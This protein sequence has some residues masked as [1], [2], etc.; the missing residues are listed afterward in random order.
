MKKIIAICILTLL[1]LV[2]L[3]IADE[4]NNQANITITS[5]NNLAKVTITADSNGTGGLP[6]G[7]PNQPQPGISGKPVAKINC[8]NEMIMIDEPFTFHGAY[9]AVFTPDNYTMDWDFGDGTTVNNTGNKTIL[10]LQ[11]TYTEKGNYTIKM[12][13]T[14]AT[15]ATDKA[16]CIVTVY[17]PVEGGF[18]EMPLWLPIV[19]VVALV[20][21][22]HARKED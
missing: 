14:D 22:M 13:L 2:P 6:P 7:V 16:E 3:I 11:H 9:S 4:A 19:L 10:A 20:I 8:P 12:T 21:A 1:I 15:M 5:S 17:E 18:A